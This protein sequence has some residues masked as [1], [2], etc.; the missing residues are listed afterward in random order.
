MNTRILYFPHCPD[1]HKEPND[2][3]VT[4]TLSEAQVDQIISCLEWGECFIP[5]QVG[6]PAKREADNADSPFMEL[7]RSGFSITEQTAT[8]FLNVKELLQNFK[9]CKYRWRSQE[10]A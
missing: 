8:V 4:G 9:D 3:V 6:L 7:D 10:Y 1:G 2:A 5:E